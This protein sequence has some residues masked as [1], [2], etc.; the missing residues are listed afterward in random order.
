MKEIKIICPKCNTEHLFSVEGGRE[1]LN[2]KCSHCG[3]LLSVLLYDL[4]L[5]KHHQ[6]T[7]QSE[8]K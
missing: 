8:D 3:G 2:A 6:S 4:Q 7:E 1:Q 5:P